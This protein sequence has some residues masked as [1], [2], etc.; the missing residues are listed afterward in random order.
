LVLVVAC[1]N[2]ANLGLARG[3][4]REGEIADRRALGASHSR[5]VRE[6]SAARAGSI[7]CVLS[8]GTAG[9]RLQP[10]VA[11]RHV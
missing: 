10:S 5:L 4:T 2:L 1:T 8:A 3:T 9:V 7:L 11:L 6:Q